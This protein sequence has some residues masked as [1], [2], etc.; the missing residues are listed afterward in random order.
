MQILV[1]PKEKV[2][3][4]VIAN[5]GS[6]P[7][8]FYDFV[9]KSGLF[10]ERED[11]EKDPAYLQIIPYIIVSRNEKVFLY[12]RLKKGNESRLHG[13]LSAGI[14][15]HVDFLEGSPLSNKETIIHNTTKELHE[16]LNI[17]TFGDPVLYNYTGHLIYDSSNDVGRVHLG[18]LMT[19]DL[20]TKEVSVREK[21]KIDGEFYSLDEIRNIY[22]ES[23]DRFENWTSIAFNKLGMV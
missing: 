17:T 21:D 23:K 12:T 13:N 18:M 22:S 2:L 8:S 14:G 5:N 9:N 3:E 20:S 11:A 19:C 16:E 6:D 1:V 7:D 4:N 10:M 15:G